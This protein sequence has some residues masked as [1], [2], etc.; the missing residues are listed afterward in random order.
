[1]YIP[2][3][4]DREL[5]NIDMY[6][7]QMY[8]DRVLHNSLQHMFQNKEIRCSLKMQH[9]YLAPAQT[10]SFERWGGGVVVMLS[11]FWLKPICLRVEIM[12]KTKISKRKYRNLF[13][14]RNLCFLNLTCVLSFLEHMIEIMI[15]IQFLNPLGDKACFIWLRTMMQIVHV[16]KHA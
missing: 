4:R 12:H 6:R 11:Y 3:I 1:M 5:W 7:I 8:I 2:K 16:S 10:W 14:S 13:I 15:F 9:K